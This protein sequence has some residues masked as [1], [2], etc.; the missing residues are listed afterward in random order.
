MLQLLF[1]NSL[2]TLYP[3]RKL[4]YPIFLVPCSARPF[5]DMGWE[6]GSPSSIGSAARKG[7]TKQVLDSAQ[8]SLSG[9]SDSEGTWLIADLQGTSSSLPSTQEHMQGDHMP[10]V[11]PHQDRRSF[12]N[13]SQGRKDTLELPS[14]L[15]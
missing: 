5:L 11:A 8:D 4:L 13:G 9:W 1:V 15:I 14:A 10:V 12:L 2:L 7:R 6:A 3:C